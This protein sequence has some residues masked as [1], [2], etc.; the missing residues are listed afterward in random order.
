MTDTG[1]DQGKNSGTGHDPGKNS[2][3][4]YGKESRSSTGQDKNSKP[5]SSVK[6]SV[7]TGH[8]EFRV[9]G[10]CGMCKERIEKT[11]KSIHGVQSADWNAETKQLHLSFDKSHT[12]IDDVKK[13]IADAGHDNDKY[14]APDSTYNSLPECCLYRK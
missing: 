5:G 1:H 4:G 11:A 8:E 13:A 14:R 3:T 6:S 12:N 10:L 9:E 2:G 7:V